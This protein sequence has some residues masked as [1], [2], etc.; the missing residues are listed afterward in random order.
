MISAQ[1]QEAGRAHGRGAMGP[2]VG[3]ASLTLHTRRW[4]VHSRSRAS[5]TLARI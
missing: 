3:T 5:A 1:A 2:A 4:A